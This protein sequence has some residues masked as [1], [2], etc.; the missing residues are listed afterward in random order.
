MVDKSMSRFDDGMQTCN[1]E[2]TKQRRSQG[3]PIARSGPS[4][5][6]SRAT[7]RSGRNSREE[8]INETLTK[9]LAVAHGKK[10]ASA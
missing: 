4:G 7:S 8:A 9:V 1:S 5:L 10:I 6:K 2:E 3:R